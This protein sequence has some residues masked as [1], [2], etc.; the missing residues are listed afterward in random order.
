MHDG[1]AER[2]Q[3]PDVGVDQHDVIET[4]DRVVERR[5][6]DTHFD[7][8]TA[9]QWL[10]MLERELGAGDD[11]DAEFFFGATLE[12]LGARRVAE[13]DAD[14]AASG[15]LVRRS[16]RG[17]WHPTHAVRIARLAGCFILP[18]LTVAAGSGCSAARAAI[19]ATTIASA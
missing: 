18:T 14:T 5:G 17:T 6:V 1:R 2:A 16:S 7:T 3:P 4:V 11:T 9:A 19:R 12:Q 15:A 8:R 13:G 10:V